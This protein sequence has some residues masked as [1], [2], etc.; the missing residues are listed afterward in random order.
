M[1]RSFLGTFL[2][3]RFSAWSLPCPDTFLL[4]SMSSRWLVICFRSFLVSEEQK[5]RANRD[6]R[7]FHMER[8]KN[9]RNVSRNSGRPEV[10]VFC[11]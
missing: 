7:E 4:T 11:V 1:D 5:R 8:I 9:G 3:S 2:L 10:P 6:E